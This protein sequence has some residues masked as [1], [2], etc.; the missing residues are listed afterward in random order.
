MG[1]YLW[2]VVAVAVVAVVYFMGGDWASKYNGVETKSPSPSSVAGGTVKKPVA[3]KSSAPTSTKSYTELVKEYEGRRIQF[4]DSCLMAPLTAQNPTY[5]NGTVIM[6]DN[7]SASARTI[8]VGGTKYQLG[9][10]GYKI[11]T[12]SGTNLP[13]ELLL[14]CDSAGVVGKILLQAQI[15][16]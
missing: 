8:T 6:L 1:K 9:S 7:R 3:T 14:S 2:I 10:Y 15:L 12:L 16:Q 5:K 13:K 11:I 4:D